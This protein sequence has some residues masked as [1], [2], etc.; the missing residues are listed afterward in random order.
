MKLVLFALFYYSSA[1]CSSPAA[2]GSGLGTCL[3]IAIL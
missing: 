2:A 1:E 3:G